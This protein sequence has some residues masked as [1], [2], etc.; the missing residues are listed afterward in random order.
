MNRSAVVSCLAL[1]LGL[2]SLPT[3]AGPACAVD[4]GPT[5]RALVELYTSEGCSSCPPA[6]QRLSGLPDAR[7]SAEQVVPLALHVD[8]WDYI[9]WSDPYAQ[10]V[11]GERQRWLVKANRGSTVFTPHMFVSGKEVS[12]WR[13]GLLLEVQRVARLPARA[14]LRVRAEAT[15]AAKAGMLNIDV[16]ASAT[17]S[18]QATPQPTAHP[19]ALF[20]AITEDGLV[21]R[22]KAGENAGATLSHEHV[23][24]RWLGPTE[25]VRGSAAI[26]QT[27]ALDARWQRGQ[28][29]VVAFVQD[30]SSGEVLQVVASGHC[31]SD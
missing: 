24:R 2:L 27:I 13:N 5:T 6:D 10:A 11:F 7:L 16:E 3:L 1:A 17:T 18:V 15:K 31:L 30:M 28:L 19:L 8:Y 25:L 22:V 14:Q 12:D 29:G 26:H 4:S 21:S 23:V 20:I 9:G